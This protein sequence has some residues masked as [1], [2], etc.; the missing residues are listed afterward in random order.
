MQ[1][2]FMVSQD[3]LGPCPVI[4]S[5]QNLIAFAQ[6]PE[7]HSNNPI[8]GGKDSWVKSICGPLGAKKQVIRPQYTE[9]IIVGPMEDNKYRQFSPKSERIEGKMEAL[10][11]M[12]SEIGHKMYF[13]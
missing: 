1:N 7:I 6:S 8:Q 4:A 13:S 11:H 5:A 9:N 12:N 3:S 2:I 10:H